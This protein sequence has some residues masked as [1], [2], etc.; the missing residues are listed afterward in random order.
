MH[1][2]GFIIRIYRDARSPESQIN[3]F[4]SFIKF[5][6]ILILDLRQLNKNM[7]KKKK[8]QTGFKESTVR[9]ENRKE[10]FSVDCFLSYEARKHNTSSVIAS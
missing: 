3:K 9:K 5:K 2:V 1:L 6:Q 10:S 8:H 4:T 7:F